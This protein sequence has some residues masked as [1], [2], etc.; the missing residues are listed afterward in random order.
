MN[1]ERWKRRTLPT[2]KTGPTVSTH[3][4]PLADAPEMVESKT[5]DTK[6]PRVISR[7]LRSLSSSSLDSLNSNSARSTASNRRLHKTQNNSGSM[8]ERIHRR[9]SKDVSSMAPAT[10]GPD[11]PLGQ[12]FTTMELVSYGHLKTDVSILKARSEYLVLTDQCLI[13]F[14]SVEA[15]RGI[16]PQLS[17]P[18]TRPRRG[19]THSMNSKTTEVRFEIPLESIVAVFNEEGASPRFGI[20]VWWFSQW[21]RLAYSK[22]H[23]FFSL[24]KERDDWLANIQKTCRVKHRRSSIHS[25]IPENLR[26]RINHIIGNS[27]SLLADFQNLIFPVAKRVMT[28]PSKPNSAEESHLQVD[29]SSFYFVIG[30]CMCYLVEV[31]KADY[32]TA[33]GELRVKSQSFG[34]VTLTRFKASVASQEQ[35]FF[36]SFR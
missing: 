11:T 15:A 17:Q 6:T 32:G 10:E 34:T 3:Y 36:M 35:R 14:G 4:E 21:P 23:L 7:A 19:S 9:V 1:A 13:K 27:E 18:E 25:V 12:S 33:P 26:T 24:P 8:I 30:P 16:F 22:A 5:I 28:T 20:E 29:G 31:L 2:L